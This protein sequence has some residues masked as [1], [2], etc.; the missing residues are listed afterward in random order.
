MRAWRSLFGTVLLLGG[1]S[2]P[3]RSETH[4]WP[5]WRGPVRDGVWR[6]TGLVEKFPPGGPKVKWRTPIEA[7]YSGPAVAA[8]RVYLMDRQ[9]AKDAAGKP[10]RPTMDGIPGNE[11]VLC[12]DA[13]GGKSI[14]THAYDCPYTIDYPSGPRT[15]PAVRDGWV[16]V[17]GAMGDLRC[18]D[19]SKGTVRWARQL[20]K[21]YDAEPPVWGFAAHLLLDGDLVYSLVGGQGSAV[22]A[23]NKETGKEV[24]RALSSREVGY[25]PPMIYEAGG[26][27]QLIIWLSESL[28]AL[29][30]ATGQLLWTQQYPS[31]GPPQRPAVNIMTPLLDGELLLVSTFYHGPMMLELAQDRPAARVFWQGHSNNPG[32]PDGLHCLMA[33]PVIRDGFVYGVGANGE[34]RCLDAQTGK[35]KWETFEATTGS[36]TD[37]ATAFLIPQ[38][39]RFVIFNDSGELLLAELS[40]KGFRQ[41]SRAAV[42]EPTLTARGRTVVWSHP[43]CAGRCLFVRN[44]KELVCLDVAVDSRQ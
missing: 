29:D 28:N 2:A 4:D 5:Q 27:R 21:D 36:S 43:A 14:W 12:F 24:W 16:Y 18:L 20:T 26:R 8:G 39:N 42:I 33:T 13:A 25:S 9:R 23:F 35:Q 40:P 3:A 41:I 22:V 7:G 11:R 38:G 31:S 6:E 30:P 44:D 32:R 10:L 17:L 19:D 37:C 1:F 15:T 34:L